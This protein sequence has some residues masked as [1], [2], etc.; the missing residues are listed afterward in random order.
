MAVSR[1][2]MEFF[3]EYISRFLSASCLWSSSIVVPSENAVDDGAVNEVGVSGG[4]ES[5]EDV[6][7][8][9]VVVIPSSS[10]FNCSMISYTQSGGERG[11]ERGS[12]R[13][14]EGGER[15]REKGSKR[16][17]RGRERA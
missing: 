4:I 3:S 15:G 2:R 11:D 6:A 7:S 9:G 14:K 1:P 16:S 10:I 17:E 5:R 12:E 8:S 13:E